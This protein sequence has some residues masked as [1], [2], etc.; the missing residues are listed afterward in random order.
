MKQKLSW[1]DR[2]MAAATFAEANEHGIA[3]EILAGTEQKR[4][5]KCKECDAVLTNDLNGA[6]VRK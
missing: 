4:N 1:F 2:V 5:R 6:E 3:A